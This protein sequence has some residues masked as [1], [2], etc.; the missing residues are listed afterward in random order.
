MG[1]QRLRH[2]GPP[3]HPG[4]QVPLELE[5]LVRQ[6]HDIARHVQCVGGSSRGRQPR[7]RRQIPVFDQAP[8]GVRELIV[9]GLRR[10][11]VE[12]DLWKHR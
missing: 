3:P 9:E 8:Q 12:A 5:L 2:P 10:V 6:N 7:A 4:R 1:R 11:T